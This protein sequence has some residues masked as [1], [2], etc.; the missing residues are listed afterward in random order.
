[1]PTTNYPGN[2][3]RWARETLDRYLNREYARQY[4]AEYTTGLTPKRLRVVTVVLLGSALLASSL[5]ASGTGT[6]TQGQS[7][8][9]NT[10]SR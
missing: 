8:P 10:A 7:Q 9:A 3:D 1:M 6:P 4:K 5:V 2:G